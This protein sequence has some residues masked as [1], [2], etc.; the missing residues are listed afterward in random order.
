MILSGRTDGRKAEG[1]GL[2]F[3]PCAWKALRYYEAVSPRILTAEVLTRVGPL[4]IIVVY[5]P[6]N[7]ATEEMRNQ[8]YANLD[9]V[10]TKTNGLTMILGDFIASLGDSIPGVIGPH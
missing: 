2:A 10:M 7:Q 1:V 4:A 6:T 9:G 3:S 5:A 8:F